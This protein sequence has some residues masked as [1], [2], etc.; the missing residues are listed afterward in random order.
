MDKKSI[1]R[2]FN[3]EA[4]IGTLATANKNGEVNSAVFGSPRMID[5]ETVIMAIGENRSYHNLQENPK[6]AFIVV[7]PGPTPAEW[8]GAR[9]YLEVASFE[10]YGELV[11]SLREKIR[12][13]AGN[14]A[15]NAIKAAIRFKI[16]E[17]RPLIDPVAA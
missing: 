13:A 10:G 5:E 4:R 12:K 17:V 15:A 8:I 9:V 1:M 16:T 3:K 2:L 7:E 14:E 11:D 6:A